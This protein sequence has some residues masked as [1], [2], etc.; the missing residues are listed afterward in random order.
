MARRSG[1][2]RVLSQAPNIVP[3]ERQM[4]GRWCA[5]A[6]TLIL[7]GWGGFSV[8]G[9]ETTPTNRPL[10]RQP[11]AHAGHLP[12]RPELALDATLKLCPGRNANFGFNLGADRSIIG[13]SPWAQTP[14]GAILRVPLSGSCL[15]SPW[16]P[17]TGVGATSFHK[18]TDYANALG[19]PILAAGDGVVVFSGDAGDYGQM[20]RLLHGQGVE[21]LYA[22]LNNAQPLPTIGT[23]FRLGEVIAYLGQTGNA[24]GPHLHFELIIGGNSIDPFAPLRSGLAPAS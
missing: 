12:P 19:T 11:S 23:R 8:S 2:D 20:L 24:T 10:A 6:L 16:G 13:F 14:A 9:C 17:R 21:T 15:S 3:G 22:H 1:S 5:R 4:R 7:I 18:G